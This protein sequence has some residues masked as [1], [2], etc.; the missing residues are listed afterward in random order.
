MTEITIDINCLGCNRSVVAFGTAIGEQFLLKTQALPAYYHYIQCAAR[1]II[2]SLIKVVNIV[3]LTTQWKAKEKE[4]DLS[5]SGFTGSAEN[6]GSKMTD[7]LA[8]CGK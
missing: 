8:G 2:D 7:Q 6:A 4:E 5:R 1:L 3:H